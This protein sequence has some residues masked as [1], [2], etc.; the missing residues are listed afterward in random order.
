MEPEMF[1]VSDAV[2]LALHAMALLASASAAGLPVNRMAQRLGVSETHLAKVMQRL[3]KAGLATS[4]RG[5]AGGFHL[6]RPATDIRL[7]DIFEA[8]DGPWKTQGCLLPQP[9][10]DGRCCALGGAIQE[11]DQQARARLQGSRLA[12]MC[13]GF[14]GEGADP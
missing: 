14:G 8:I 3:A 6:G 4:R 10:C 5:P 9:V 2:N 11:L 1:H 13:Q 7:L 12:D